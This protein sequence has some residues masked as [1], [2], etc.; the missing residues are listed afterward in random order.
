LH[1]AD[2]D[3][4]LRG[5][6]SGGERLLDA[7]RAAA[8][9]DSKAE[10]SANQARRTL[11]QRAGVKRMSGPIFAGHLG[12]FHACD[13]GNE[14]L[15]FNFVFA[16]LNQHPACERAGMRAHAGAPLQV[17]DDSAGKLRIPVKAAHRDARTPDDSMSLVQNMRTR[18]S[19]SLGCHVRRLGG[20]FWL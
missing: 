14:V 8:S 4:R 9:D 2:N 13:I 1:D 15:Y 17:F 16:K 19:T 5:A 3:C 10:G 7:Q 6:R 18:R 12:E 11:N 20:R